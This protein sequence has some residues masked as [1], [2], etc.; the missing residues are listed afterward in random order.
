MSDSIPVNKGDKLVTLDGEEHIVSNIELDAFHD[1]VLLYVDD[2]DGFYLVDSVDWKEIL[3]GS[4]AQ[5]FSRIGNYFIYSSKSRDCSRTLY[6]I[7]SALTKKI[8]AIDNTI[9][10]HLDNDNKCV[11]V[12]FLR[13]LYAEAKGLREAD[14]I[15][16]DKLNK[17]IKEDDNVAQ[18]K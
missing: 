8:Q 12:E 17:L 14:Q 2:R 6:D 3:V 7:Q 5:Y 13:M 18:S 4:A 10:S 15:I 1:H 9:Y 11:T 16:C